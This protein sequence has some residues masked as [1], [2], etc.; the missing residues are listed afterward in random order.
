LAI[1]RHRSRIRAGIA[2]YP[3]VSGQRREVDRIDARREQLE[4][5]W[6]RR[7]R[8]HASRNL[9]GQIPGD[10]RIG[11][12]DR[13]SALFIIQLKG[14]DDGGVAG[15]DLRV[16]PVVVI[17]CRVAHRYQPLRGHRVPGH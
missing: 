17:V 6:R 8:E 14:A 13:L 16:D 15:Q 5:I 10:H 1:L 4:K 3:Q 2:G 7:G 9:L 12:P 11:G